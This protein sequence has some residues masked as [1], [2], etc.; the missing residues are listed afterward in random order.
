MK[1]LK[2][3][4]LKDNCLLNVKTFIGEETLKTVLLVKIIL[5]AF[6]F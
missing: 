4:K 6:L 2:N 3:S 5:E 1:I